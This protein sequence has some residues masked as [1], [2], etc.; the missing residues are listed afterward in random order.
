MADCA[1][2]LVSSDSLSP[3][4]VVRREVAPA[5][6]GDVHKSIKTFL[7][8]AKE[9]LVE[10]PQE[11]AV[12]GPRSDRRAPVSGRPARRGPRRAGV[13]IGR[14][15]DVFQI[16]SLDIYTFMDVP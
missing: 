4:F 12:C 15:T 5:S 11:S 13:R 9:P 3:S 8:R 2:P 7:L 1:A 6:K 16:S 14:P 10:R